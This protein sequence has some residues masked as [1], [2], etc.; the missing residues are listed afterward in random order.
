MKSHGAFEFSRH[1]AFHPQYVGNIAALFSGMTTDKLLQSLRYQGEGDRT[2]RQKPQWLWDAYRR[3]GY[4]VAMNEN[5][6]G[7]SKR[8]LLRATMV[9]GSEGFRDGRWQQSIHNVG[10][11]GM[12]CHVLRDNLRLD[13]LASGPLELCLHGRRYHSYFLEHM[14]KYMKAHAPSS[15]PLADHERLH[16]SQRPVFYTLQLNEDRIRR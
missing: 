14:I 1:H 16:G 10:L 5:G 9:G 4:N 2:V 13:N 15:A 3:N 8:S 12:A 7:T 6:C 11:Q